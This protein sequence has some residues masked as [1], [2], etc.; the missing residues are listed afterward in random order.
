MFD[1]H[2]HPESSRVTDDSCIWSS[3]PRHASQTSQPEKPGA[4]IYVVMR[5]S[6][7]AIRSI[8]TVEHVTYLSGEIAEAERLDDQLDTLIE[9]PVMDDRIARISGGEKHL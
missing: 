4:I 9:P 7:G 5:S 2:S 1:Q 8:W 6:I 3:R